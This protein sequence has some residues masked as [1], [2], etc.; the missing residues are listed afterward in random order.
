MK[1][2]VVFIGTEKYLD[3]LPSWYERCEE[4]FLP[5]VEKKYLVFT[6]GDVPESPDNAVVYKQEHLDWPY[7][8]LYRFKIIQKALD[9]IVGCDWLVFLDADMAVVDTVTAPEI[10]TDKPYI[11]VHHPCHFL[12]FPPH[13]QPPGSFETNPLSTAKVPDDYDF[14]IYWQGCLWGGKTSEVISMMEELNARIS[15]DEENNVI[16]QWHDESHLNAFYAQ[17]KNLVHTLG[18][19]FAFPEVFAEAC[20]F[21]AK[22]V[23]LAKDNSKYHV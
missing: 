23:H 7:I 10:F 17:N 9:E 20:E 1:V 14:S 5:G 11:G 3:F 4:N 8:T 6:D 18:P 15:L 22:I 2:A 16:A 12:K 21:Q 13:N 19:E